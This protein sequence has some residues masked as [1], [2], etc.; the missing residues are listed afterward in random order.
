[1]KITKFHQ[2]LTILKKN[3]M[4]TEFFLI[5]HVNMLKKDMEI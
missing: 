2:S 5:K 3:I 1:M 4:K